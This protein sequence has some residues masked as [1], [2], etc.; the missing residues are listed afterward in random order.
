MLPC[1]QDKKLYVAQLKKGCFLARVGY[2]YYAT[3]YSLINYCYFLHF[4]KIGQ[5]KCSMQQEFI[6]TNLLYSTNII[7]MCLQLKYIV[8]YKEF[9][10]NVL[11]YCINLL[12]HSYKCFLQIQKHGKLL[13]CFITHGLGWGN[14]TVICVLH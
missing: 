12:S 4:P 8:L 10:K 3:M 13:I 9:L 11:V 1:D 7:W 14:N 2:L 6:N 5:V